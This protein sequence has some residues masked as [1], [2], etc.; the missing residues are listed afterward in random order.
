MKMNMPVFPLP[1]FLL[2]KGV[3]R[4]KIFEPRYLH[5][6]SIA[7][8]ENGFAIVL[9]EFI[10][11][12]KMTASWVR[13]VNFDT[14]EHGIL[15]V[16]VKCTALVSLESSYKDGHDLLWASYTPLIHWQVLTHNPSTQSFSQLLQSYFGKNKQLS[17]LYHDEFVDTPNWVMCRW[18]ELLP[19]KT[20]D[21]LYFLTP[22][23][24]PQAQGLLSDLLLQKNN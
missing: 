16:D 6:I 20:K 14:T 3:T 15:I 19:L 24:Y 21:K 13:I 7:A 17:S 22:D 23:S 2:P 5:M 11:Q 10:G 12:T 9:N 1:V 8:K 4:L 18:L